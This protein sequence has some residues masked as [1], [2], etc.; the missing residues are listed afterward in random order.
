[1]NASKDTIEKIINYASYCYSCN[2]CN[3]VCPLAYLD[4]FYPRDLVV[5][6]NFNSPEEVVKK[7]NIWNCL[8][9]G[10]CTVYCPMTTEVEGVRIPE[11]ILELR[12]TFKD[13][14]EQREKLYECETH[15]RIVP[16]ISEIMAHEALRPNKLEFLKTSHLKTKEQGEIAFFT[17]CLP[18]MENIFY[19]FDIDYLSIPET[20]IRLLNEADIVPVVLNE[21][22]CGHDILW[23]SGDAEVFKELAEFNVKLYRDAG[24]KT[25]IVACA[26]GYRTWK[27][28]YPRIIKDFDFEVLHFS[29]YFLKEKILEKV[30]FPD[31]GNIKITYH[32]SCRIGRLGGR[33]YDAP[34]QILKSLPGVELIE[35]K[36][37]R[38][39]AYCCGIT[40]FKGCNDSSHI[41]MDK[42]LTQAIRTGAE[43]LVVPCPKCLTHFYC[44]LNNR[45]LSE[46]EEGN[47]NKIKVIDLASFIG[48]LLFFD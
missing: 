38:D 14:V 43:Y 4:L 9:C 25:I 23:G 15:H 16:L 48:K 46:Q 8:T 42:R 24:V 30:R 3:N 40:A 39:D 17:G 6:L 47:G 19:D 28:D 44:H 36:N 37:N 11:L 31:V 33:L 5:D 32:D 22:C 41:L 12:K 18:L 45:P 34:R 29:E 27:I 7:T 21:K 2:R 10:Q 26:E 20:V 1:M 13:D 35:M